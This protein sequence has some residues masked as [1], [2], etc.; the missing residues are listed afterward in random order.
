ML[1]AKLSNNCKKIPIFAYYERLRKKSNNRI[2]EYRGAAVRL[3][4]YIA[5]RVE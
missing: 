5:V 2:F 3:G 1:W 4:S